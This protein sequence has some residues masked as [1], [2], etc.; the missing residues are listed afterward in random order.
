[1]K[2][3]YDKGKKYVAQ[4]QSSN[5]PGNRPVFLA[6]SLVLNRNPVKR[7]LFGHSE[8]RV[9]LEGRREENKNNEINYQKR[10]WQAVLAL[11]DASPH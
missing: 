1:M 2:R 11:P 8:K 7:S 10:Y 6:V 5:R 4:K 9:C 3:L